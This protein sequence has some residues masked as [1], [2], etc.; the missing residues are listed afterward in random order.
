M[1]A[2]RLPDGSVFMAGG[3]TDRSKNP[4]SKAI[5]GSPDLGRWTE[6]PDLPV[7]VAIT[8]PRIA[9]AAEEEDVTLFILLGNDIYE[10]ELKNNAQ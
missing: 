5:V 2:V 10:W 3:T 4:N 1:S 8:K 9:Y 7:S 6:L